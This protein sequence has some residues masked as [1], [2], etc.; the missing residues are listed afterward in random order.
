M[1]AL[2]VPSSLELPLPRIA[3]GRIIGFRR[4]GDPIYQIEGRAV[5]AVWYGQAM[6]KLANKEID[7]DSDTIKATLHTSAYTPNQD[8]HAYVSDITSEVANG[9]GYGTGGIT[10]ANKVVSYTGATTRDHVRRRRLAV[11]ELERSRRATA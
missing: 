6:L 11:D 9:N 10:L 5:S 3:I 4:N 8:T 7:L 2:E 1:R